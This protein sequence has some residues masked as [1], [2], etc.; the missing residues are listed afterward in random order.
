MMEGSRLAH[1]L[2]GRQVG[3]G[4]MGAVYQATDERT[5]QQVAIKVMRQEYT[6]SREA[7]T[8]FFNEAR[9]VNLIEHP[10]LVRIMEHAQL[11]G[12]LAYLVMEFLDG[13]TLSARMRRYNGPMPE[14]ESRRIVWLLAGALAAA[15]KKGI[16]HRDLKPGSGPIDAG[17]AFLIP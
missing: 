15:H 6:R 4:G 14:A 16:I 5:G 12:G 11:T 13:E 8:R 17:C 9:A 7:L 3:E 1:Y 2:L 10:V